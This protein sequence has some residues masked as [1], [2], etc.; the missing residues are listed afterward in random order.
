MKVC[1][2]FAIRSG[3]R[4]TQKSTSQPPTSGLPTTRPESQRPLPTGEQRKLGLHN[5]AVDVVLECTANSNV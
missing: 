2:E 3:S 4:G 5:I 1:R